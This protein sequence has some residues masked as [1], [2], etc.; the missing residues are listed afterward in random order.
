MFQGE[1]LSPQEMENAQ[2]KGEFLTYA[3]LSVLVEIFNK[4]P[5]TLLDGEFFRYKVNTQNKF[6][7]PE[8]EFIKDTS[9]IFWDIV[10]WK[11]KGT[12]SSSEVWKGRSR[13]V[14]GSLEVIR[15]WR[16]D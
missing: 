10:W 2:K 3:D 5:S 14:I 13:R 16:N 15:G 12:P 1:T 6:D 11:D 4:Y 7:L 8:K 9:V